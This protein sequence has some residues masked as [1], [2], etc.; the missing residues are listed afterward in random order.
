MKVLKILPAPYEVGAL[1]KRDHF[2]TKRPL[3]ALVEV[4]NH[5]SAAGSLNFYSLKSGE[6]VKQIKF[7]NP[8]LDVLA[9]RRSVV[10]TFPERIAVF[11][12]FTLEDKLSVTSCYLSPGVQQ[13]PVALG[14][15]WLGFAE[16]KLIASRKSSGGNEGEGVQVIAIDDPSLHIVNICVVY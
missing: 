15:R 16:K 1:N 12:A 2:E 10:I 3:I 5:S 14:P 9:N 6:Q 7:K 11:D 4:A 8:I 13:N